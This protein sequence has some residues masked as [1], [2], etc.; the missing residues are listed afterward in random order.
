MTCYHDKNLRV[1]QDFLD[2]GDTGTI[3]TISPIYIVV[4]DDCGYKAAGMEGLLVADRW[5]RY[6]DILD[7]A[8][9]KA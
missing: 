7:E 4:C 8:L 1:E 3:T 9:G 6:R 5:R 2:P